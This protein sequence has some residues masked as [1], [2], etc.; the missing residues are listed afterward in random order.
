[1]LPFTYIV[2][3]WIMDGLRLIDIP[4]EFGANIQILILQYFS[5]KKNF[6]IRVRVTPFS[7]ILLRMNYYKL[8]ILQEFL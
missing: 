6:K 4:F 8:L 7:G 3:Y 2:L 1:M 5:F